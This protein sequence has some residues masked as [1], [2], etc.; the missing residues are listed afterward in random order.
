MTRRLISQFL[1]II[2]AVS[3]IAPAGLAQEQDDAKVNTTGPVSI[4]QGTSKIKPA[5]GSEGAGASYH[6]LP[7]SLPG[8]YPNPDTQQIEN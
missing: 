2:L 8:Q 3:S 7:Y 5:Q 6:F 4:A 1:A